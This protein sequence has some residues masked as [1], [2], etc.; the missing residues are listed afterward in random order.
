MLR[1][2]SV[3]TLYKSVLRSFSVCVVSSSFYYRHLLTRLDWKSPRVGKDEEIKLRRAKETTC[4]FIFTRP[5]YLPTWEPHSIQ[6]QQEITTRNMN[7]NLHSWKCN[8]LFFHASVDTQSG[9]VSSGIGSNGH[10]SQSPVS[11]KEAWVVDISVAL[12][13]Q[14]SFSL[15][16]PW[17]GC[18]YDV[19]FSHAFFWVSEIRR[20]PSLKTQVWAQ[21]GKEEG[22]EMDELTGKKKMKMGGGG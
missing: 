7:L 4:C 13:S 14:L 3:L 5:N 2:R 11:R 16:V 12:S 9:N 1:Q 21:S 6:T 10:Q 15:C 17:S 20:L 22:K 18:S 8:D 19:Q